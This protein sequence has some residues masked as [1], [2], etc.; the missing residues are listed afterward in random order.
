MYVKF[1]YPDGLLLCEASSIKYKYCEDRRRD[2]PKR[3]EGHQILGN[4]NLT[5]GFEV[6]LYDKNNMIKAF[7]V[8]QGTIYVMND[9]GRTIDKIAV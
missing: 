8:T 1:T 7:F 2:D 5:G 4:S 9:S 6:L 3:W